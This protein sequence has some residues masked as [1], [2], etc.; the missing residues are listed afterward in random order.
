MKNIF[1]NSI[2]IIIEIAILIIAIIWYP[3]TKEWEPLTIMLA[4]IGAI[5][6]SL[7]LKNE[8]N[9]NKNKLTIKDN[10]ITNQTIIQEVS[11]GSTVIINHID[12]DKTFDLYTKDAKHIYL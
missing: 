6:T 5:I 10:N 1:T 11:E 9:S 7:L 2:T 4:S 3:Q 12:S 8:P